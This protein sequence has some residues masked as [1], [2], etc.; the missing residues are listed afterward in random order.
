MVAPSQSQGQVIALA[1]SGRPAI[2]LIRLR[3]GERAR[4]TSLTEV[5]GQVTSLVLH[6]ETGEKT[7]RGSKMQ[8]REV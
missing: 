6:W 2:A 1:R 3:V 5:S 8:M 7:A 4:I